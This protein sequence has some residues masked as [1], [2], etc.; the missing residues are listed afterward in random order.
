M[1]PGHACRFHL[2]YFLS[3]RKLQLK[4]NHMP[5][6]D[7]SV[8]CLMFVRSRCL[9][10]K[11][12]ST[13]ASG[14]GHPQK[15]PAAVAALPPRKF[16]VGIPHPIKNFYVIKIHRSYSRK[17]R[18]RALRREKIFCVKQ[19][20]SAQNGFA[21]RCMMRAGELDMDQIFT[22]QFWRD[23]WAVV[24]SSPWLVIP[25]L[26]IAFSI[27][28]KWKA[29]N[30]DGEMRGL[31][32]EINAASREKNAANERMV[33]QEKYDDIVVEQKELTD[34]VAEQDK[35]IA[36]L[37]KTQVATVRVDQLAASNAQ[38]KNA[39]INLTNQTT[40]LGEALKI[41]RGGAT[42]GSG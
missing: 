21:N 27:G 32:A 1:S 28:W 5:S 10:F 14:R 40:T 16:Y 13:A 31:R 3:D 39:L 25:S 38:I 33:A 12:A 41:V 34:R 20:S 37:R 9:R 26:L 24:A 15:L 36:E 18:T 42:G 4:L 19:N 30:D 7:L 2:F 11:H 6:D 35:I 29:A 22:T 23:Q 8:R 17:E